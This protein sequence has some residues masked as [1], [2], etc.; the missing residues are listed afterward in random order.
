MDVSI[1]FNEAAFIH[2]LTE[3]DIRFALDSAVYD[4]SIEEDEG[5]N[6]FLLIGFDCMRGVCS[7]PRHI[8]YQ[9]TNLWLVTG[10]LIQLK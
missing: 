10:I 3:E 2:H 8:P 4:G 5:E 9:N 6:K 1:E 7:T